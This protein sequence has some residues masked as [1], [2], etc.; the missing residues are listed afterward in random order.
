MTI[1]NNSKKIN[2]ALI[3]FV[4]PVKLKRTLQ[5]LASERNITISALLRLIT[6][7]Y[8]KRNQTA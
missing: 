5:E 1:K 3:K 7:E 2:G 6:T 8:A 4:A